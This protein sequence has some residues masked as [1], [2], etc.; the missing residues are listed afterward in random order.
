MTCTCQACRTRD[1]V[2]GWAEGKDVPTPPSEDIRNTLKG[3]VVEAEQ[4]RE[5]ATNATVRAEW[6]DH[7]LREAKKEAN[8]FA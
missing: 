8:P 1:W 5:R 4:A 6:A 3:L 7:Q 2:L